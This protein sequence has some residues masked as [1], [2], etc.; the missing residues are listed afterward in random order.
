MQHVS[1]KDFNVSGPCHCGISIGDYTLEL[2]R[3]LSK[4]VITGYILHPAWIDRFLETE[5][6]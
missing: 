1:K 4:I 3:V 2:G 5:I 6:P